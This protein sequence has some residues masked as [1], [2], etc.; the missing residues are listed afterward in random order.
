MSKKPDNEPEYE[1]VQ[2]SGLTLEALYDQFAG[3]LYGFLLASL[4][5]QGDA[6]DALQQCFLSLNRKLVSGL[7]DHPKAYLYQIA[8]NQAT[9]HFRRSRARQVREQRWLELAPDSLEPLENLDG[10]ER[11]RDIEQA[12]MSLRAEQRQVVAL[13]IWQDM[14]FAQIAEILNIS[15]NTVASRYRYALQA[16]REVLSKDAISL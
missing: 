13:K 16:L 9:D 4:G 5:D 14:T 7:P 8:R 6:E 1:N 15:P 12:M 3:E 11:L 2:S 10:D